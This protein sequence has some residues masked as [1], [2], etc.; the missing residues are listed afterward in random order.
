MQLVRLLLQLW[1]T[2]KSSLYLFL[3]AAGNRVQVRRRRR[4]RRRFVVEERA[5]LTSS[6]S[7]ADLPNVSL[8]TLFF[9]IPLK[10]NHG[11]N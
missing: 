7:A 6:S 2:G 11:K 3:N 8:V 10:L 5:R 4:R 9:R 1:G